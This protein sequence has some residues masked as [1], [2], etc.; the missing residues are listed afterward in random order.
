MKT[1]ILIAGFVIVLIITVIVVFT[2]YELKSNSSNSPT[3][4]GCSS[5]ESCFNSANPCPTGAQCLDAQGNCVGG[6]K[7]QGPCAVCPVCPASTDPV[8]YL[9]VASG[10][11]W[12]LDENKQAA[13]HHTQEPNDDRFKWI[14]IRK[15]QNDPGQIHYQLKNKSSGR[16][17][18]REPMNNEKRVTTEI[19]DPKNNGFYW[20]LAGI[21]NTHWSYIYGDEQENQPSYLRFNSGYAQA[22]QT[23]YPNKAKELQWQFFSTT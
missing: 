10:N 2:F 5:G 9:Q 6:Q 16:Y 18:Y 14:M 7:C 20:S 8:F 13:I 12:L 17:L 22:F 1:N 21:L 3:D 19:L 11:G 15:M 4:G 23:D